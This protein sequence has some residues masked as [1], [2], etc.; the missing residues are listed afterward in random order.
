MIL[1]SAVKYLPSSRPADEY[2]TYRE[3][4]E[5]RKKISVKTDDFENI[6]CGR[7]IHRRTRKVRFPSYRWVDRILDSS[8]GMPEDYV[9]TYFKKIKMCRA[10]R[11]ALMSYL[12]QGTFYRIQFRNGICR[13]SWNWRDVYGD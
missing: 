5:T 2:D 11:H 3:K 12:F 13:G 4:P 1:K 7:R 8:V 9:R 10:F 6:E